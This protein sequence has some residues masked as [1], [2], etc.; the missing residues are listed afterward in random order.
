MAQQSLAYASYGGKADSGDTFYAFNESPLW[1]RQ[2]EFFLD[3][4]SRAWTEGIVPHYVTSNPSIASFY[5]EQLLAHWRY[6]LDQRRLDITQPVYILE[7]GAGSGVFSYAFLRQLSER[8]KGTLLQELKW[9]Y[10]ISDLVVENLNFCRTH[11]KLKPFIEQGQLDFAHYDAELDQSIQLQYSG[12]ILGKNSLHNTISVIANYI[13]D[14]LT[15][16]LLHFKNGDIYQS[17]IAIEHSSNQQETLAVKNDWQPLTSIQSKPKNQHSL[18]HTYQRQLE[19]ISVL[20]P[21][22][23]LDVLDQLR[24]W[25]RDSL[26]VLSADKGFSTL[27]QWIEQEEASFVFHGSFSLPVNF[28]ALGHY[29]EQHQGVADYSPHREEG[30]LFATF[31]LNA[32]SQPVIESYLTKTI[33]QQLQTFNPDDMY[34]I[35]KSL[36]LTV[37]QLSAE[38]MLAYVRLSHWDYRVLSLC[39][40]SLLEK[41]DTL[42]IHQ[43]DQWIE[44]LTLSYESYYPLEDE[45]EPRFLM[46]VLAEHL[47]AWGLAI[48]CFENLLDVYKEEPLTLYHMAYCYVELGEYS[49][50]KNML[51]VCR[52]LSESENYPQ[53]LVQ[54][55]SDY[56]QNR[57]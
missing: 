28:H 35:K 30:L 17:H 15:Q 55:L 14:G 56:L 46:G 9:V 32:S 27:Q 37:A 47:G 44:A 22:G 54:K 36:E 18:L 20:I 21:Q 52:T 11:P 43:R 50:A 16:D 31:L 1:Q 23:A 25:S 29:V 33:Q 26:L 5:I 34:L 12:A 51:S 57:Q 7:L 13:F 10:V 42:T 38:Q 6:A 49:S 40:P 48:Q 3:V 45:N 2:R 53:E 19:D 8:L 41:I 39:I 24:T 4:G